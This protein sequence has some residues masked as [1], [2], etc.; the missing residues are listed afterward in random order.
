MRYRQ[1]DF[2]RQIALG[3]RQTKIYLGFQL[4]HLKLH[5]VCIEH[6]LETHWNQSLSIE[7]TK[8]E[9]HRRDH[10]PEFQLQR[11]MF[12]LHSIYACTY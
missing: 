9:R 12:C 11:Q 6:Q 5:F 1:E 7:P 4:L 3:G 10:Y 2:Q 8:N